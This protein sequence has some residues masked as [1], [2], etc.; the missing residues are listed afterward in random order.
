MAGADIASIGLSDEQA[1]RTVVRAYGA[2][3]NRHDMTAMAELFSEDAHWVNIVGW[4]WPGKPSVVKG[5]EAI[6]RTFFKTQ[7][8]LFALMKPGGISADCRYLADRR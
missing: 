4:H 2:C 3:W 7:E 6:H 8:C 5:H 1:I